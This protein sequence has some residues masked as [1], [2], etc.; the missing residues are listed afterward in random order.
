MKIQPALRGWAR[1]RHVG[2]HA[3]G[4]AVAVGLV[5]IATLLNL[6]AWPSGSNQDGHYFALMTAI[7]I[8]ALYGGL[9]PGL[10][11]TALATVSSSYFILLPQF[12]LR[13][14]A[15]GAT[16]RL[17]VF[18]VEA[19]LLNFV[20][21]FVRK[22][23]ELTPE[24]GGLGKYLAVP[25]AATA[26][27]LP[28]LFLPRVALELPFA[29]DYAAVYACA[30]I[31]GLVPGIVAIALLAGLAK[32]LFLEPIYSLS[33]ANQ[34]D[35][36][37]VALF[38]GEGLLL[39]LLGASHASLKRLATKAS[40]R[41]RTYVAAALNKEANNA[42][43]RAVSRDTVWE[44]ELDSGA[45][46]RTPSWQDRISIALPARETFTSWV[47]RIHPEDRD[48][49]VTRLR[50]AID[51]GREEFQYTYRLLAPS[52]V[53][54]PVWDH[55]FVVRGGDWKALR[56]IGRSAELPSSRSQESLLT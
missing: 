8:S 20:A 9:G 22:H 50:S 5:V 40:A 43:I 7:L 6:L 46:T 1:Q 55:A 14:A 12:S 11:A 47:E 30:W 24:R 52:G 38:V 37:R 33:V 36:V 23:R 32:F 41:A 21:Y 4:F 54:L 35:L 51:D 29:F 13:V 25:L 27:T 17:V 28:K 2:G 15:P 18:V 10:L 48:A 26:A 45:I 16:E 42:A 53:F 34:A 3:L 31:G 56:V 49:I 19:V 44:W 39:A